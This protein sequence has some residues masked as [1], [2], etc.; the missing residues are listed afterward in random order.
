MASQFW[1]RVWQTL[2]VTTAGYAPVLSGA[3]TY[4]DA[5]E[6]EAACVVAAAGTM[7]SIR[8]DLSAAPGAG[9]SRQFQVYVNG[10]VTALDVTLSDAETSKTVTTDIALSAADRVSVLHTPAGTPGAANGQVSIEFEP[11]TADNYCYPV[12]YGGATVVTSAVIPSYQ[13]LFFDYTSG[14]SANTLGLSRSITPFA[15]QITAFFIKLV[16]APSA[17]DSWDFI[18]EKG[19][20]EEAASA[21]NIAETATTG[22]LTGLTIAVAAGDQWGFKVKAANGTPTSSVASFSVIYKPTSPGRWMMGAGGPADP[23]AATRFHGILGVANIFNDATEGVLSPQIYA[24]FNQRITS[25]YGAITTAPSAG[26]GW[27]WTTRV[28]GADGNLTFS[29]TD[30]ETADG[31][32]TGED[33]ITVGTLLCVSTVVTGTPDA[34]TGMAWSV[35]I[36]PNASGGAGGG[37]QG[38]GKGGGG[39]GGGPGG[40]GGGGKPG[41]GG[42]GGPGN[43]KDAVVASRGRRRQYAGVL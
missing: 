37:G 27:A 28:A 19:G 22:S 8:V 40:G 13:P 42:G 3:S 41:G 26:E 10:I 1:I 25:F 16:T 20:V 7:K 17:G 30:A 33:V 43:K 18:L 6:T 12:H 34:S 24:P 39:G 4:I 23:D 36:E 14:N 29:I 21:I 32:A 2:H 11:T 38:K 15:G 9:L 31:V 5:T 35:G